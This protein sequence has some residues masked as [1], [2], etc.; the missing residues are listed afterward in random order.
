MFYN[1]QPL[2]FQNREVVLVKRAAGMTKPE[3]FLQPG[4]PG[5]ESVGKTVKNRA[6]RVVLNVPFGIAGF[7]FDPVQE[8]LILYLQP[9]HIFLEVVDQFFRATLSTSTFSP[10]SSTA[11]AIFHEGLT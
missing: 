3:Q 10:S 7:L 1:R 9:R 8:F 5:A 2:P 6:Y 11:A 4:D